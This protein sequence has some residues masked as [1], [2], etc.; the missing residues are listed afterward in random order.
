M[1]VVVT[2]KPP[3]I[4]WVRFNDPEGLDITFATAVEDPT[5]YLLPECEDT[6]QYPGLIADA[7]ELIFENELEQWY[8]D[9]SLWPPERTLEMFNEWFACKFHSLIMDLYDAPLEDE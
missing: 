3:L 9:D 8:T 4:E 1:A 6:S 7:W 5:V 2:A